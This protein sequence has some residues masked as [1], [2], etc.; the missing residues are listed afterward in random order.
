M[1]GVRSIPN[2]LTLLNLFLGCVGIVYVFSDNLVI[3]TD[4]TTFRAGNIE[5]ACYLIFA[6]AVVDLLDG[7]FAR[8]F[9]AESDL[10][11]QL[12]SLADLVSFGV[13]PGMIMFHL[14]SES[15]YST[16][17][18][19]EYPV[20]ILFVAF[21]IPVFGA[22]RLARYNINTEPKDHFSGMP[23]P[24]VGLTI[25]GL[26]LAMI[27]DQQGYTARLMNPWIISAIIILLSWLMVSGIPMLSIKPDLLKTNKRKGI[28]LFL[29]GSAIIVLAGWLILDINFAVIPLVMV[30]YIVS[31]IIFKPTT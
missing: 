4:K 18:S 26:L 23:I 5:I 3:I 22:L 6:A 10:G 31:S 17:N 1:K 12:D 29:F 7:F 24:A 2:F 28:L 13:L 15:F 25:A 21:L 27:H 9:K 19:M 8:I 30:W 14:F 20:V 16:T 11:K